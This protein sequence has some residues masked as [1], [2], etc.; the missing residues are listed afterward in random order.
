MTAWRQK[1]N[2]KKI[3]FHKMKKIYFIVFSLILLLVACNQQ[4]KGVLNE[5]Q[6]VDILVR[7]HSAEGI[8]DV[9]SYSQDSDLKK[10]YYK[11]ILDQYH[12]SSS[13]F[14]TSLRWYLKHPKIYERVYEKVLLQ[15]KNNKKTFDRQEKNGITRNK[16]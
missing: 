6:M 3:L 9:K 11:Y 15:L 8:F 12:I 4:P 16:R 1:R 14:D 7:I 2:R 5:Q 13:S 10:H